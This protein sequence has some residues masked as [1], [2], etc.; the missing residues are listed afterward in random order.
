MLRFVIMLVAAIILGLPCVGSAERFLL[1]QERMFD[2]GHVGIDFNVFH[3]YRYINDTD[4]PIKI[5]DIDVSCDCS[6]VIPSDTVVQP[7]D[8][9]YFLLTFNTADYF[10]PTNK[11]FKVFTDDPELPEIKYLIMATVGQWFMGLKPNNISLFFIPGKNS[12]TI[13]I[14]N[15]KFDE[16]RIGRIMNFD[17]SFSVTVRKDS[18]EKGESIELEVTPAEGKKRGTHLSSLTFEVEKSGEKKPA[19]FSIPVKIVRY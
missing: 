14:L 11:S 3:N 18:A 16:I 8:T 19:I 5:T 10:G 15:R 7:G 17:S 1:Y 13:S 9:V 2:F 4:R 12:N 6:T